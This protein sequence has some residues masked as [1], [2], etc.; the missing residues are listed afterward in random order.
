MKK[1]NWYK[2]IS[3]GWTCSC[4]IQNEMVGDPTWQSTDKC[5]SCGAEI[6]IDDEIE[7]EVGEE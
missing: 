7:F 2:T 1:V 4:G 6:I 3:Y 5:V